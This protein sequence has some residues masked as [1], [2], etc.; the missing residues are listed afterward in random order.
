MSCS[1]HF[2]KCVLDFITNGLTVSM[3]SKKIPA[4]LKAADKLQISSFDEFEMSGYVAP[5]SFI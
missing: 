1:C 4:T 2:E 5:A 3:T